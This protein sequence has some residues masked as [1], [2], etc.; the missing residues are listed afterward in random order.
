MKKINVLTLGSAMI[1]QTFCTPEVVLL[2]H[3][4]DALRQRLMGF[5]YGAKIFSEDFYSTLGGGACNTAV[6]LTRLGFRVLLRASVGH[7]AQ[8]VQMLASLQKI[9]VNTESVQRLEHV[10]TGTSF[11][12]VEPSAYEH[13]VFATH[14]ANRR[15]DCSSALLD[16]LHPDAL[17]V[18]PLRTSQWK[19]I[20]SAASQ[21]AKRRHA[22]LAWNPGGEQLA[23]GIGGLKSLLS[24]VD[25]LLLNQDEATELVLPEAM[26]RGKSAFKRL[27]FSDLPLLAK[28]IAGLGPAMVVVT[29]GV[30]GAGV[31]HEGRWM[32]QKSLKVKTKDTTGAG[33]CF[34][35]TFVGLR[36][37]GRTPELALR[38]AAINAASL[39]Q[40][41]GAQQGLLRWPELQAKLKRYRR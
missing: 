32:F 41:V 20:V 26:G 3:L 28:R 35:A 21:Y 4:N 30:H 38:G 23:S 29:A 27:R 40:H 22:L 8:G 33:D 36:L 11:I 6:A 34:G 17:F 5:E 1:D 39:V 7:D 15:L 14:G 12:V 2:P 16:Q 19:G 31:F 13:V 18:A 37:K 24:G 25:V 9:G 10:H